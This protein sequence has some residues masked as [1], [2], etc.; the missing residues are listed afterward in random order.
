[1]KPG[2]HLKLLPRSTTQA[3]RRK[4]S[5]ATAY[6][7]QS[8]PLYFDVL[9]QTSQPSGSSSTQSGGPS[10][11]PR[12]LKGPSQPTT[13]L[14][15]YS[16]P[17]THSGSS[18][19]STIAHP[20]YTTNSSH[21]YPGG[22][23]LPLVWFV[24]T[25]TNSGRSEIE[26]RLPW[27]GPSEGT[28]KERRTFSLEMGAYGIPKRRK[29]Q[30]SEEHP[31]KD[32]L[33]QQQHARLSAS[34]P[35]SSS[36]LSTGSGAS[37]EDPAAYSL[38]VQV[39]EDAYFLRP[40]ALGVADGVGGWKH[41]GES[42][43]ALF[44]KKLMH[45][46]SYELARQQQPD[47]SYPT[48][49]PSSASTPN[50]STANSAPPPTSGPDPVQILQTSYERCIHDAKQ[51]GMLGSSTATLAVLA[52]SELR[53]AHVGDCVVCVVRD[54]EM[55]FRSEEMQHSF[56]YPYQLGPRSD[57]TPAKHAQ[58]LTVPVKANDIVI[59]ASDGMGDNLWDEDV[60]D[61]I[62]RLIR[63]SPLPSQTG[64]AGGSLSFS[65]SST[66]SGQTP[67]ASSHLRNAHAPAG[68]VTNTV[69][70]QRLSEALASRAK[71]VS[72]RRAMT[73]DA[74]GTMGAFASKGM[75]IPPPPKGPPPPPPSSTRP[76]STSAPMP[77]PPRPAAA[78]PLASTSQVT[79]TPTPPPSPLLKPIPVVEGMELPIHKS[80]TQSDGQLDDDFV[81]GDGFGGDGEYGGA[82]LG[83]IGWP[84]EEEEEPE[85]VRDE[86]P[87]G[88]R[89]REAGVR[90]VG[91]KGDDISV[92]V[93][94]ISSVPEPSPEPPQ[95]APAYNHM[96]SS[97]SSAIDALAKLRL[98]STR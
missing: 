98:N 91:G 87:F 24:P 9:P 89:A 92:L 51:S 82:G 90:F 27:E 29:T 67:P 38:A 36:S 32:E 30:Q 4:L 14:T 86:I 6:T 21:A 12:I 31:S 83:G 95:P 34:A 16:P 42:N 88:R 93:A 23:G 44:A 72:E 10:S 1:M 75:R 65:A 26:R 63:T 49:P 64:G 13:A 37:K 39:G 76:A 81:L 56:N 15:P 79:Q 54:G 8:S 35:T 18:S 58:R 46:C 28:G 40:D 85:W 55:V 70:A 20:R 11:A 5:T 74:S 77:I 71:R 73:A 94:I 60:V 68:P 43:S 78:A 48:P 33:H 25:S 7:T 47:H 17:P 19:T 80:I 62:N 69:L 53:I 57:T 61:E 22:N 45:F 2:A 66:T 59:L 41:K 84:V 52:E 97:S 50:T 96:R 3:A